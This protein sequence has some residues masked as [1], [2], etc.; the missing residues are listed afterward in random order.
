MVGGLQV[1]RTLHTPALDVGVEFAVRNVQRIGS[2]VGTHQ[3][4]ERCTGPQ[5]PGNLW[6]H[7]REF[8]VRQHQPV[9][10]I[11]DLEAG[12][13]RLHRIVE[14]LARQPRIVERLL[15]CAAPFHQLGDVGAEGQHTTVGQA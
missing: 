6:V 12:G 7:A 3:R 9:V 2:M 10:G 5:V 1:H 4:L 8:A 11:P 13:Q 14:A 15:Q